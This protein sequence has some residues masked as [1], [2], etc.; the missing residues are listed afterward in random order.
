LGKTAGWSARSCRPDSRAWR[1]PV[2]LKPRRFTNCAEV[3]CRAAGTAMANT[4]R[5]QYFVSDVTQFPGVAMAWA[6]RFGPQP[7]PF[8]CARVREPCWI[9]GQ[10]GTFDRARPIYREPA[11]RHLRLCPRRGDRVGK[12]QGLPHRKSWFGTAS[13]PGQSGYGVTLEPVWSS[14]I[15]PRRTLLGFQRTA[16]SQGQV[17]STLE[18]AL[19]QLPTRS[20][21][22]SRD[23]GLGKTVGRQFRSK[24][25][26]K[27]RLRCDCSMGRD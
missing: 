17:R 10:S 3:L 6:G 11:D 21:F 18:P 16:P 4:L 27:S 20:R 7:H 12:G 19:C 8:V 1:M 9:G 23:P 5:A 13:R 22:S 24:R 2:T 15:P 14:S 26:S 25:C